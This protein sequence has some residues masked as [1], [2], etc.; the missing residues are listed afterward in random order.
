MKKFLLVLLVLTAQLLPHQA[1]AVADHGTNIF[2]ALREVQSEIEVVENTIAVVQMKL[3][4]KLQGVPGQ[5]MA[6]VDTLK[7][8][9]DY[10]QLAPVMQQ[11]IQG[12][13]QKAGYDAIPDVRKY[14][15]DKFISIAEGDVISQREALNAVHERLNLS[16]VDA[17]KKAKATASMTNKVAQ[18]LTSQVNQAWKAVDMHNK[19]V[20][21][22]SVDIQG[23]KKAIDASQ[24][25]ASLIEA[26]AQGI[27][28]DIQRRMVATPQDARSGKKSKG[29][30]K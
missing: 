25:S 30:T 3:I 19:I 18:S 26:K 11:E 27:M 28:A 2:H 10:K 22:V 9:L 4:N 5:V 20:S 17:F 29:A 6:R 15:Q 12:V 24:M 7:S 1:H 14:V 21:E 23:M 8:R 16:A 13:V